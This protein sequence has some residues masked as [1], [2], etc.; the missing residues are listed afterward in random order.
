M[1]A[2]PVRSKSPV[3]FLMP[4]NYCIHLKVSP[5]ERE[6]AWELYL[7]VLRYGGVEVSE[8][9]FAFANE[10]RWLTALE[11][12]RCQFGSEYFEVVGATDTHQE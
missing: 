12:L 1:I 9:C 4:C 7:V 3:S 2:S 10:Q 6:D 11:S 8:C 5:A